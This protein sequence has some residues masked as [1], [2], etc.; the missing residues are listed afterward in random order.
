MEEQP[1]LFFATPQ[2]KFQPL[3]VCRTDNVLVGKAAVTQDFHAQWKSFVFSD[4]KSLIA[5][6]QNNKMGT[7]VSEVCT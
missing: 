1:S 6:D 3:K 5:G 2:V 7:I 4:P